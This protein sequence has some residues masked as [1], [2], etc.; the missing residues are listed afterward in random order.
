MYIYYDIYKKIFIIFIL[1]QI[2]ILSFTKYHYNSYNNCKQIY[3]NIYKSHFKGYR[4]KIIYFEKLWNGYQYCMLYNIYLN[5]T[6]IINF[7]NDLIHWINPKGNNNNI[8]ISTKFNENYSYTDTHL[9]FNKNNKE[10]EVFWRSLNFQNN[11]VTIYVK[12]TKD[13]I[14]WSE[15]EIFI[16]SNDLKKQEYISPSIIIDKNIYKIWYV[17]NNKIFYFECNGKNFITPRIIDI[18][19]DKNCKIRFID[20]FFNEEK[21]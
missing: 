21:K 17:H 4:P 10:L 8:D 15:K 3:L 12:K 13:C 9:L 6:P 16:R 11:E 7:S 14:N 2:I 20:I 19:Y 1:I 18:N 5:E